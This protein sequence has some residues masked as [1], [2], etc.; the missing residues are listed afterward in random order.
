MEQSEALIF[1]VSDNSMKSV[2]CKYELNY[3]L[4]LNKP[5]YIIMKSDIEQEKFSIEKLT[6]KWF[7]DPN[8]KKLALL[9]S[10]K[11]KINT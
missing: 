4:E 8:Y 9:E 5:M 3:F 11:I 2:W 7:I 10:T 1:V 6:D